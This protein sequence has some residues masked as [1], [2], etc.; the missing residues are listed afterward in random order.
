MDTIVFRLCSTQMPAMRFLHHFA[1]ITVSLFL[2]LQTASGIPIT[3][4]GAIPFNSSD[5]AATANANALLKT[6]L[7]ANA[8]TSDRTALVPAG[9][10][11]TIF[12]VV[13]S[14]IYNVVI[15]IDGGLIVSDN[16]NATVWDRSGASRTPAGSRLFFC[17]FPLQSVDLCCR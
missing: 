12:P 6:I 5:A 11:F 10:N 4:F 14:N 8:S 3:Q 15:Q 1:V 16:I 9:S 2:A 7:A 17:L 13:L